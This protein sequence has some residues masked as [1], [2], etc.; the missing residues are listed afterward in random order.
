M[1][2]YLKLFLFCMIIII[3]IKSNKIIYN[4]IKLT[5][6]NLLSKRQVSDILFIN[7]CHHNILPHPH[8]YL[9][10]NQMEQLNAGFL[11]SIEIFYLKLN[12]YIVRDFH[13]IIFYRCPWTEAV[14]EAIKLAKRLNKKVFFDI[15]DLVIDTKYTDLIPYIQTLSP[16]QK[17]LYDDGVIRIKKT[18][19]L[20]EAAIT[21]TEALAKELKKYIPEVFINRN[22]ASEEMFKLSELAFKKKSKL[23]K[24]KNEKIIGYFS[25]SITHKDD[26]KMIFPAL[27]KI[28]EEFKNVKLFLMGE[29]DLPHELEKYN[30]KIIIKP[31]INWRKLPEYISGV[32]INI[33][34][35]QENIFNEAKSENKWL[36]ASLVKV[37]T[38]ASNFGA[39][40][41]VIKNGE[42]GL[43][44]S[45]NE[46]WYK[47][48]K[49]LIKKKKKKKTI[50]KNA[51]EICKKQYNS[52]GTGYR[53]SNHINSV[54]SKHK[55]VF[56]K[57]FIT[58]Y[59]FYEIYG[60]FLV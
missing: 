8:R 59:K 41:K 26:I 21:T 31:F 12:P 39:F 55:F 38:I 50:S 20:C 44:C 42:T 23:K 7:G 15:D 3:I 28:F 53:L 11:D 25:G 18:L 14:G 13:V 57:Y 1:N 40:R 45:N 47:A 5:K 10:L 52:L 43:L 16:S 24:N 2:D 6:N 36:E 4:E 46:E 19:Q 49:D 37:P 30:S 58:I 32:D 27:I 17:E 56:K 34:P 54:A 29:I 9:V 60:L 51:F 22:V 35:I 48:L 33:A